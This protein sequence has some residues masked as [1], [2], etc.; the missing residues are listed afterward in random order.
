MAKRILMKTPDLDVAVELN[1]SR[2]AD[3]IWL[4]LPFEAYVNVWGEEIYFEIPVKAGIEN[5]RKVMKVG[6]VAYWPQGQA[7]CFF[8]GPTPVSRG[9]EP[10]AISPVSPVGIVVSAIGSLKEI[11]DRT[12]V[13]IDRA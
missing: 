6:E 12:H 4:A 8:F 2:T 11:G 13:V 3:A 10:V 7:L 9:S 5:G 1:E